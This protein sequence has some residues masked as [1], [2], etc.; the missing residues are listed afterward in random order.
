MHFAERTP[1]V[2]DAD[3]NRVERYVDVD[4]SGTLN[5]GD[6]DITEY[7]WDVRNRLVA[8]T[9][10]ASFGAAA[11][12]SVGYVYDVH[13]RRIAKQF[14][15]DADG[16]VDKSEHYIYDGTD[17]VLEFV[18]ADGDTLKLCGRTHNLNY[19]AEF[20]MWRCGGSPPFSW[21]ENSPKGHITDRV[22]ATAGI[23]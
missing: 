7:A 20:V 6:T 8:V 22:T 21:F 9:E 13:N 1:Y 3:G 16:T 14:D 4:S 10:R 15:G 17:V 18:D 19:V 2:Y 5:T 11:T 23:P 12:S